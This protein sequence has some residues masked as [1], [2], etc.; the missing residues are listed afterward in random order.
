MS[1]ASHRRY[2]R[3]PGAWRV[4]WSDRHGA[5]AA[6]AIDIG[7][8]GCRLVATFMPPARHA[9]V[10]VEI[11]APDLQHVR[12]TGRVAWVDYGTHFGVQFDEAADQRAALTAMLVGAGLADPF[13]T[14]PPGEIDRRRPPP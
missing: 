13:A 3:L 4:R 2:P 7:I 12:F 10:S 14:P 9:A 1:V 8:G 11:L 6:K 5:H